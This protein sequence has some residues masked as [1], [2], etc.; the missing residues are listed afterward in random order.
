MREEGEEERK[1]GR[2]KGSLRGRESHQIKTPLVTSVDPRDPIFSLL[3][4][5]QGL[6]Q[7]NFGGTQCSTCQHP[8]HRGESVGE[9]TALLD[10]TLES[11]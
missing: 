1:T 11:E 7:I 10:D 9:D 3:C 2:E 5:G 6:Q 8:R 4:G